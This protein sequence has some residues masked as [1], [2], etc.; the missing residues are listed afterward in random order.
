MPKRIDLTG[1]R[2]GKIVVIGPAGVPTQTGGFVWRCR[3][4]CGNETSVPSGHLRCGATK[5]CGCGVFVVAGSQRTH[6]QSKTRTYRIWKAMRKRCQNPNDIGFYRYGGRGISVCD[7]WS[8]FENFLADMGECPPRRSI[9][10]KDGN[11]NY[12]PSNCRWATSYEQVRNRE[13]VRKLELNG[14]VRTL[15]EWAEAYGI[16]RDFLYQR[17]QRGW[18]VED[19]LTKPHRHYRVKPGRKPKPRS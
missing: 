2:F 12:E 7:R 13:C 17:I 4:D 5:S 18:A 15:P 3:C 9:D 1:Q 8:E 10:R 14:E 16:K 19:A 11:G 6:G